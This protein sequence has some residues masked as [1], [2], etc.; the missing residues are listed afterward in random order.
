MNTKNVQATMSAEAEN[1]ITW[2]A[3]PVNVNIQEFHVQ[4]QVIHVQIGDAIIQFV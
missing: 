1:A 4:A 2:F 3:T